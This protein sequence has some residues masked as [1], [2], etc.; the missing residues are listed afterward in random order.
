MLTVIIKNISEKASGDIV[1]GNYHSCVKFYTQADVRHWTKRFS[2]AVHTL[3]FWQHFIWMTAACQLLADHVN[4]T[5]GTNY[6]LS[7][8][9]DG[10]QYLLKLNKEQ[11]VQYLF[12]VIASYVKEIDC[13]R[14]KTNLEENITLKTESLHVKYRKVIKIVI[15]SS[16]RFKAYT[17][18]E[19]ER[20]IILKNTKVADQMIAD[21]LGRSYWSVVYKLKE[22]RRKRCL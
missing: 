14:Y 7:G 20:M 13:M 3:Y 15:S 22:L 17:K 2:L 21:E 16:G 11:D 9:P 12:N 5:F 4:K 18:E 6:V 8:H 1:S 19:I 10:H